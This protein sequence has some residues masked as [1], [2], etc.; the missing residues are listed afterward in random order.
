MKILP[1]FFL[2]AYAIINPKKEVCSYPDDML[3][4][5][6]LAFKLVQGID[7]KIW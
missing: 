1:T 6:G 2:P 4:G 5:A 3:C 7:T